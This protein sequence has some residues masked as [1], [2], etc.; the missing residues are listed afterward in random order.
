LRDAVEGDNEERKVFEMPG[1]TP[2]IQAD[3]RVYAKKGF[4]RHREERITR[5]D[6]G[7][8]RFE[9]DD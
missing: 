9:Y 3:G 5:V 7:R 8:R 1:D 2:R 4:V 6:S